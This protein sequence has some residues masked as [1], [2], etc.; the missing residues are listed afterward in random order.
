MIEPSNMS[1]ISGQFIHSEAVFGQLTLLILPVGVV[2]AW[3]KKQLSHHCL[4]LQC[5]H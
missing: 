4:F 5:Y 1:S 2:A 3:L